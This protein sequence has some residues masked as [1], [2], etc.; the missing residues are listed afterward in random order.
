[1]TGLEVCCARTVRDQAA[2]ILMIAATKSRRPILLLSELAFFPP[3]SESWEALTAPT[4]LALAVP[5]EEPST[6][7]SGD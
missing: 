1:M 6:A 7:S 3:S 5:V 2:V 4:S